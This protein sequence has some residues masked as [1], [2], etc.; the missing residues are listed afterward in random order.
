MATHNLYL[1]RHAE[2]LNQLS[3]QTDF[4]RELT[5]KGR[6]DASNL[7]KYL[8]DQKISI[9]YILSSPAIRT[10]ATC[11]LINETLL[12][13][14]ERIQA[15]DSMYHASPDK[16]LDLAR[17]THD[18]FQHVVILGHNPA[19][20]SFTSKLVVRNVDSFVPAMLVCIQFSIES[21]KELNF[22]TGKLLFI[23]SPS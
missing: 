22:K 11:S 13:P 4:D 23:K 8:K 9:D 5:A 3:N 12:L 14:K 19:I 17:V 7:G 15:I 20:S 16:L 10:L 1:I 6:R 18:E 2:T 21:W